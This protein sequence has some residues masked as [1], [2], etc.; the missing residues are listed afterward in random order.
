MVNWTCV[1]A[2]DRYA[3][4]RKSILETF[5]HFDL[6]APAGNSEIRHCPHA[7]EVVGFKRPLGANKIVVGMHPGIVGSV[8]AAVFT[9]DETRA[10]VCGFSCRIQ[11]GDAEFPHRLLDNASPWQLPGLRSTGHLLRPQ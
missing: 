3:L 4:P 7:V 5:H 6:G 11:H 1:P 8:S 9:G 10:P 2:A